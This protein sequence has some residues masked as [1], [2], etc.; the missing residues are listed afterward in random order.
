MKELRSRS[1]QEFKE[2]DICEWLEAACAATVA[3]AKACL[4][5]VAELKKSQQWW[6]P[7]ERIRAAKIV[8][9]DA[10]GSCGSGIDMPK[11]VVGSSLVSAD[12][13]VPTV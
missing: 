8:L 5:L 11:L 1:K 10:E 13:P 2:P 9:A 4:S 3:D 7:K 12:V 6:F